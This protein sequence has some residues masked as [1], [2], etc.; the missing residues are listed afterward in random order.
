[1]FPH[2]FTYYQSQ[3]DGNDPPLTEFMKMSL[4]ITGKDIIQ[5]IAYHRHKFRDFKNILIN[6]YYISPRTADHW[7]NSL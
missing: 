7:I 5:E 4:E 3:Q 2:I 1:M 6:D